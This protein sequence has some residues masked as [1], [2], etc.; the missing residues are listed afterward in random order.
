MSK[1]IFP[2]GKAP[3]RPPSYGPGSSRDIE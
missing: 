1:H 2:G 3:L